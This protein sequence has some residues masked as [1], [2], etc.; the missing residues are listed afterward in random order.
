M[1]FP[2]SYM[3]YTEAFDALPATLKEAIY[4]RMTSILTGKERDVRYR[5]FSAEDRKAVIG[6]LRDTKPGLPLWFGRSAP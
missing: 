1:R 5:R 6:I 3:I 2:C 4:R